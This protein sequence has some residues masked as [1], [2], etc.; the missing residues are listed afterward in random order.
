MSKEYLTPENIRVGCDLYFGPISEYQMD[1]SEGKLYYNRYLPHFLDCLEPGV[2][3]L[4]SLN[5]LELFFKEMYYKI[6]VPFVLVTGGYSDNLS[7]GN[8]KI[9]NT[10]MNRDSSKIIHW[11]TIN[12]NKNP[13]PERFS[14]I[15]LGFYSLSVYGPSAVPVM[16]KY[17]ANTVFAKDSPA[18]IDALLDTSY[19]IVV[20]FNVMSLPRLRVGIWQMFCGST[21]EETMKMWTTPVLH[22]NSKN[23]TAICFNKIELTD[24]YKIVTRSRFVLSPHGAGLD[25]YR[26]WETLLLGA[27]PVVEKGSLDEMY[28]DLPVLILDNWSDLTLELLAETAKKFAQ[29]NYTYKSLY[30][31]YYTRGLFR[32]YGYPQYEYRHTAPA[33]FATHAIQRLGIGDGDLVKGDQD[34]VFFIRN[35][36]RLPVSSTVF[37]QYKWHYWSIKKFTDY[38]LSE[39]PIGPALEWTP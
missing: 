39:I 15:P 28:K 11:Y 27:Y 1:L 25:C 13:D 29:V 19:D 24:V 5:W 3:I 7:P 31:S 20:A 23:I 34:Q 35:E 8:V 16:N 10:F 37:N 30:A 32:S 18:H 9:G 12:C 26:T 36:T 4:V 17:A 2:V 22:T 21:T 33:A 6:N 14:C 38:A